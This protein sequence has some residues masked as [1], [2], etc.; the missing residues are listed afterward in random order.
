MASFKTLPSSATHNGIN[1][2]GVTAF[3]AALAICRHYS[4]GGGFSAM[5]VAGAY[6]AVILPLEIIYLRTPWRDSAGFDFSRRNFSFPRFYVKLLGIYGSFGF[7]AL[8]YWLFPEYH[9]GYYTAYWGSPLP[10]AAVD[11]PARHPLRGVRRRLYERPAGRLLLA[12]QNDRAGKHAKIPPHRPA[13][14]RLGSEGD[15]S[16]R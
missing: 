3:F 13:S 9:A 14:A 6:A 12:G 1:A 7:I 11:I 16:C 4:I 5:I 8:L 2:L 15:F 10:G